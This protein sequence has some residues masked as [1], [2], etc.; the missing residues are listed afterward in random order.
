M[1]TCA[2][3]SPTHYGLTAKVWGGS[4]LPA[5]TVDTYPNNVTTHMFAVGENTISVIAWSAGRI[6]N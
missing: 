2:G 6:W 1:E 4:S 3:T 5:Y